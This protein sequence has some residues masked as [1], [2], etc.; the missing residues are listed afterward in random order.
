MEPGVLAPGKGGVEEEGGKVNPSYE[1]EDDRSNHVGNNKVVNAMEVEKEEEEEDRARGNKSRAVMMMNLDK[2]KCWMF[3]AIKPVLFLLY[4]IYLGFA[5]HYNVSSDDDD[6]GWEWCDGL[7]F[8]IIVTAAVYAALI[9]WVLYRNMPRFRF[10][11]DFLKL[12]DALLEKR[13]FRLCLY[14]AVV[15][16][17]VVFIA[18]DTRGERRRLISAGGLAAL[19]LFGAVFSKHRRK[20]NWRQVTWGLVLQFIFGLA[21]L[22]WQTGKDVVDCLGM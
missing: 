22:R 2:A 13:W 10:V 7:G 21:I 11:D 14:A 1:E 12:L 8:V 19:V 3:R 20:I 9:A 6:L 5:I 16:G 4:N 17:G 15:L 18:V